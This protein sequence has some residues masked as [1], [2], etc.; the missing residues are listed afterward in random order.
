MNIY[1]P[2]HSILDFLQ[3]LLENPLIDQSTILGGDL[4]F[5]IGH[6]DFWGHH[7]QLDPLSD[8]LG[9][10]L[11]QHGLIDVPMNKKLPT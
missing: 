2:N 11:E 6:E 3:Q 9:I 5:S 4:N 1:A 8:Q 7:S 10:L